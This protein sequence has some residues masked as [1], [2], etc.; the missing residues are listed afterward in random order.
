MSSA[1]SPTFPRFQLGKQLRV[2]RE[3]ARLTTEDVGLQLDCSPSTISRM[4]GGKVGIRRSTLE[5]LLQIY[6]VDDQAHIETLIALA[7]EGKTRGWFARYG[8]LPASY[9]RYIGLESNAVEM[10]DYEALVVPGMLQTEEYTRALLAA[11]SPGE[12]E[13]AVEAHVK[14]RRERQGLLNR[15][16]N[17]LQFI[18]VLDESVIRRLI[19]GP[20]IMRS[21][22]KHLADMGRARNVTIQVLPF[23]GGAYAGMNGSFAIL[24]FQ[25][26]PSVVYAEAMAGDIYQEAGDVQRY[27]DVFESL[28]AAALSP[29]ESIKMIELA[30]TET[31]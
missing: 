7:R 13:D 26:A 20:D 4:E 11:A 9:S 18:A 30:I 16:E 3:K 10:R 24:K 29:Y 28:R 17:P 27:H 15:P 14:A 1:Q 31:A 2:L 5:R 6:E 21:Q 23:S 22:L 12:S 19:G 25:D 8:D